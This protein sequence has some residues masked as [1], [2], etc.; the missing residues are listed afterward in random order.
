MTTAPGEG[1]AVRKTHFRGGVTKTESFFTNFGC[2]GARGDGPLARPDMGLKVQDS[3]GSV[4]LSHRSTLWDV[5][6]GAGRWGPRTLVPCKPRAFPFYLLLVLKH[7]S[8]VFPSG[9]VNPDTDLATEAPGCA[10][11]LQPPASLPER[12]FFGRKRF[13][14]W[15]AQHWPQRPS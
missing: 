5:C 6:P 11:S 8:H 2:T 12:S 14:Q 10:L 1:P 9:G 13:L 4:S 15:P 3:W 7:G